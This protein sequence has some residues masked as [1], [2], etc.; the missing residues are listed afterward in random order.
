MGQDGAVPRAG[1]KRA[2]GPYSVC[3]G[4]RKLLLFCDRPILAGQWEE[5]V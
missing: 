3:S 5:P 4:V 2:V 1:A